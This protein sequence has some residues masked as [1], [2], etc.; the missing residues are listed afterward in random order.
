MGITLDGKTLF[1]LPIY[2]L[3]EDEYYKG[4]DK[5]Y[6]KRKI[7]HSNTQYERSLNQNLY[8][9]FGGYWKYN[10]I[11]GYLRFYKYANDVRCYYYKD[12]KKRIIKTRTKQFIP[13][14]DTLY[15]ISIKS[16]Y[17]NN[18]IAE[19]LIEMVNYC[20]TLEDFSKRYIDRV[21]FDN[22]VNF[23]DWRRLIDLNNI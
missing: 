21:L 17:S 13:I 23:I 10:E 9:D 2:R 3:S 4:L 22:T 16:S 19:K 5:Y 18:Q 15:K 8:K 7:P 11:I 12:D 20:S 14:D 1:E 6:Q